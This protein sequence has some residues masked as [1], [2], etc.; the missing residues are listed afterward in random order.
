MSQQFDDQSANPEPPANPPAFNL[1]GIIIVLVLVLVGIH[2]LR[3]TVLSSDM[4]FWVLNVFAFVPVFYHVDP[5]RLVEPFAIYWSPITHGF[6]HGGWPHIL[7]NLLWFVAFGSA[8]ARRFTTLRFLVFMMLA[9]AAG[10]LAHYIF[11]SM[12]NSPVIGASGAVSA[13]MGAAI[14]FSLSPGV[15]VNDA[16][17]RPALSLVQSL[18]NRSV[19]TF[20]IIWFA[21]NW[22]FGS[23]IVPLGLD[24]QIAWEAHVGGFLFGWLGFGLFDPQSKRQR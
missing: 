5:Q 12:D 1:P 21:L 17:Q 4:D 7:T 20:V 15:G 22:A 24:G 23:G 16:I 19:M 8:L 10:A 3:T 2:L 18:S 14:R 9:T 6:L 13:C 11:H